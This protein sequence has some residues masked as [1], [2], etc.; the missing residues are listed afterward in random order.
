MIR[1]TL[2]ASASAMA[3]TGAALAADLTPVP[4]PPPIF[5]WNGFYAGVNV[6]ADIPSDSF[7]T[8]PGGTLV[9]DPFDGS[10][11]WGVGTTAS[12][13][14]FEGGGQIGYNWQPIPWIVLGLET[15]IQGTTAKDNIHD[16]FAT[17]D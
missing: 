8:I 16:V 11:G 15:D 3:L 17:A 9:S 5:S 13:V 1:R 7:A 6:G 10:D 14:N 4:P 2:L 12:K